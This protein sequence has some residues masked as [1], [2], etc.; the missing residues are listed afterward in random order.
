M[1]TR[2]TLPALMSFLV[3]SLPALS[4][5]EITGYT[6]AADG[7]PVSF[8]NVYNLQSGKGTATDLQ[9][10]FSL[11]AKAGDSLRFSFVGYENRYVVVDA[12]YFLEPL[13]VVLL[14]NRIM[15]REVIVRDE[16]ELPVVYR[17]Q[18]TYLRVDGLPGSD[19][20]APSAPGSTKRS[21]YEGNV[22]P[23]DIR[24]LKGSYRGPISRFTKESKELRKIIRVERD[25]KQTAIFEK[26]M[27]DVNTMTMLQEKYSL[28]QQECDS[29]LSIFNLRHP[30]VRKLPGEY[31][32]LEQIMQFIEQ[33][34]DRQW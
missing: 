25:H 27:G 15:L 11:S 16:Y 13:Y 14:Q 4:Q 28:S 3:L 32:I 8:A 20:P 23:I 34:L 24:G 22:V 21:Q 33:E 12:K 31:L 9:G 30:E 17:R 1:P 29:L 18:P 10:F 26:L 5:S 7:S 2:Y 6:S 19:R